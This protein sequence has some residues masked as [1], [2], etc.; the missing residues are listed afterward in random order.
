MR[1]IK[2]FVMLAPKDTAWVDLPEEGRALE[3]DT[4]RLVVPEMPEATGDMTGEVHFR[5]RRNDDEAW[6]RYNAVMGKQKI[7]EEE[8]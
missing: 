5:P 6:K 4:G 7:K 8:N 2:D 1:E 3:V